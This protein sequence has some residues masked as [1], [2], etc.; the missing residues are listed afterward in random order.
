MSPA[1][2]QR[3]SQV[4]ITLARHPLDQTGRFIEPAGIDVE[5]GRSVC[6]D[7]IENVAAA[8]A[9]RARRVEVGD[10]ACQ[11]RSSGRSAT[12]FRFAQARSRPLIVASASPSNTEPSV[13]YPAAILASISTFASA[14]TSSTGIFTRS[15]ISM[16]ELVRASNLMLL[17]E[18]SRW[19]LR[20][21]SQCQ[22]SGINS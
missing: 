17:I 21:P 1:A 5:E 18:T 14:G 22:T 20:T 2:V 7:P 12:E 4:G 9:N 11:V 15:P 3:Y 16:P 8:F 19:I 6:A 13:K 10:G